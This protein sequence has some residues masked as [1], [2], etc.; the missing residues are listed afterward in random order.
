[1]NSRV[2]KQ[3]RYGIDYRA[4]VGA[5]NTLSGAQPVP[6]RASLGVAWSK[7]WQYS[8]AELRAEVTDGFEA[9]TVRNATQIVQIIFLLKTSLSRCL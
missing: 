6:L 8:A 1:M 4:A 7:Y 9:N 5:L 3:C 2:N